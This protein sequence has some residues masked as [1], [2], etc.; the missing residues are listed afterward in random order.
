M[1]ARASDDSADRICGTLFE[2][3]EAELAATDDY[4][5]DVY[6]RVEVSLESGRTAFIYIAPPL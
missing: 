4:E 6:G 2:I 1:I 5:V 3:S